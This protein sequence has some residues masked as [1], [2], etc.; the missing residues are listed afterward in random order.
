MTT[1]WVKRFQSDA[2]SM[3]VIAL[4]GAMS[5]AVSSSWS[6]PV[7]ADHRT[8]TTYRWPVVAAIIDPFR[9]PASP[10][11]AG[12]RGVEL[13][14]TPGTAVVAAADG[15]VSF[16]GPVAGRRYV[17]ITHADGV[18]TSYGDLSEVAV[19]RGAA[20]RGGALIGRTSGPLHVSARLG[21]AYVDPQVLFGGAD[22]G[23][24]HLVHVPPPPATWVRTH[25]ASLMSALSLWRSDRLH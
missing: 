9:A 19:S 8:P 18:R 4:L 7:A 21:T 24:V 10:Y 20:V 25:A 15:V 5:L 1:R 16:A 12:N 3:G 6:T 2:R 22:A 13:G 14:T 11:A 23:R 17:T